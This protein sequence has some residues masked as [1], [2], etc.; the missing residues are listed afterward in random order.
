MELLTFILGVLSLLSLTT[1]HPGHDQDVPGY[2]AEVYDSPAGLGYIAW[3]T[4]DGEDDVYGRIF[5][6]AD[7]VGRGVIYHVL[8]NRVP[9]IGPFSKFTDRTL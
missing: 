9:G 7:P 3:F 4:S 2:A 8:L 5:A 6:L 1:A